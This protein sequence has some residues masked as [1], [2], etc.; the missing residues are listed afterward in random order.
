M[1]LPSVY[2]VRSSISVSKWRK[3]PGKKLRL[4]EGLLSV[5]KT[6]EIRV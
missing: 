1:T 4:Q 5:E 3:T 6:P 2:I